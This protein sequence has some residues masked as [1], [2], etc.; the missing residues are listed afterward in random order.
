[1]GNG[2]SRNRLVILDWFT[3]CIGIGISVC[4]SGVCGLG[5]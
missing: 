2:L 1:M 3:F 4:S 5:F